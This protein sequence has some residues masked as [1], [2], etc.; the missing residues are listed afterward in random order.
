LGP[1]G[2]AI[3]AAAAGRGAT[4]DELMADLTAAKIKIS[5]STAGARLQKLRGRQKATR[6]ESTP[7]L[8]LQGIP[9]Q[10]LPIDPE[11]LA[12]TEPA[13]VEDALKVAA[14]AVKRASAQGNLA[15]IA[16]LLRNISQLEGERRKARA[17]EKPGEETSPEMRA[18][19]AQAAAKFHK[20]VDQVL[21]KS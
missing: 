16:R 20:M 7:S 4:V 11:E 9:R 3:I 19:G 8:P 1:K 14:I 6:A 13:S 17:A 21:T 5:R 12:K 15:E 18:L 10:P 2:E